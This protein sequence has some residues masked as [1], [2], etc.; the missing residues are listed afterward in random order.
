MLEKRS[1]SYSD[2]PVPV[3]VDDTFLHENVKRIF[4][5]D[6]GNRTLNL[7]LYTLCYSVFDKYFS[8]DEWIHK[9]NVLLFW[10]VKP[11]VHVFQV[12]WHLT[13]LSGS[14]DLQVGAIGTSIEW[15]AGLVFGT[16]L[17]WSGN[18]PILVF[19]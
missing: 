1:M 17:V 6:T 3:P 19:Y 18:G 11:V 2:G 14:F 10:Q 15:T 4:I 16:V 5:C 13:D 12:W 7:H 8:V 9:H